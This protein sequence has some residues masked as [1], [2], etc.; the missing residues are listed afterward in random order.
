MNI[1]YRNNVNVIYNSVSSIKRFNTKKKNII[2]FAGKLN[3]SK[4]FN[5]FIKVIT[6][7][8]DKFPDLK[9]Y[10]IGNEKR[11][12]Y[13]VNHKNIIVK[14]WPLKGNARWPFDKNF[15]DWLAGAGKA[16]F[17]LRS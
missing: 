8:L 14:N 9:S 6:K 2:I 11:E 4:G 5:I 15:G 13:K 7:I 16:Y 12:K 17:E 3:K 10:V 1:N